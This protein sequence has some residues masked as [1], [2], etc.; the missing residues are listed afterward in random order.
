M[1]VTVEVTV[2]LGLRVEVAVEEDIV[3]R[4]RRGRSMT[5]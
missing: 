4:R 5:G 3:M 1:E 2:E